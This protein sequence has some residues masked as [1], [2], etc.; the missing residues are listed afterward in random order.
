MQEQP[1][2]VLVIGGGV[3]GA[4]AALDAGTRELRVGLVEQRDYGSGTS[5]R[6]SKMF[7]GGLRYLEQFNF[8]L[9]RE[10]LAERNLMVNLLCPHLVRPTPFVYPL[11]HPIW[12]RF[13]VG[14]GVMLYELL[15]RLA[16]NPLPWHKHLGRKGL[17]EL[18]PDLVARGGVQYW[19]TVVDDARHTMTLART[20]A[21]NGAF[22]AP[23]TR[24][25]GYERQDDLSMVTLVDLEWGH[26]IE[27]AARSV[28]N[29]TGVWTDD[30]EEMG[31]ERGIDVR[32]SKGIHLVVPRSA[33]D[34]ESGVI[35]RTKVSVLFIIPWREHWIIGTTDTPWSLRRAHPAASRSDIDYLLRWANTSLRQPIKPEDIVG[36]YAGLRPLLTGETEETS[37][38]SREHAVVDRG[39]GLITVAGGK[40][41]TYRVMAADA[42]DRAMPYLGRTAESRTA[43][44]PLIGATEL[45]DDRMVTRYGSLVEELGDHTPLVDDAPYTRGEISY[46][47]TH[48]GA[49][50]LD[51]VL[52][53]RTRISIETRPRGVHAARPSAEIMAEHLGWDQATIDREVEHYAARVAAELDSQTQSDDATADA[54]RMGAPDVRTGASD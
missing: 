48:E 40:Y 37:K 19:D 28:I 3:T 1:L 9:V 30:I 7:H 36:V 50:H 8:G 21:A 35:L 47:V 32:A 5:S 16:D 52:A 23:S 39:N 11:Q 14:A 46:A 44:I 22:M 12:E 41:T 26:Q 2:D 51:D 20:A 34:L 42:V 15:A 49:L 18:A 43:E 10:A 31:G 38:L 13:Y 54:A 24:V 25:I 6:S 33:V 27:I 29:A 53:R 4:G 17:A 45:S